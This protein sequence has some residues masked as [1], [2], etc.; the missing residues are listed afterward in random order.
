MLPLITNSTIGINHTG[1]Q[2]TSSTQPTKSEPGLSQE[3]SV[4]TEFRPKYAQIRGPQHP[5]A[6]RRSSSDSPN[7]ATSGTQS[8]EYNSADG[9]SPII[10]GEINESNQSGRKPGSVHSETGSNK[11]EE[12]GLRDGGGIRGSLRVL[13]EP[14]GSNNS[15]T[16][17]KGIP[18]KVKVDGKLIQFGPY[19]PARDAAIQYTRDAGIDYRPPTAYVKLNKERATRIAAAFDA[20]PHAPDDPATKA[21]YDALISETLAQYQAIKKTGL[22]VELI[23]EKNEAGELM[24]PY[25]NPRNVILDVINN[26]HLWISP[27]NEV[28]GSSETADVDVSGNL[29]LKPT[30]E[31]LNGH[32]LLANDIFRI[33]HDYFGH[34][35]EGFGFRAEGEENAWQQHVAMYSEKARPAMTTE[36]RG[37]N[38]WINFGPYAEFNK[39]ANV[40]DTQYAPQ[41]TGLLPDWVM[42]EGY[43]GGKPHDDAPA[44]KSIS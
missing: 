26:N 30:D 37:Q 36:L 11:A 39:T 4:E 3:C 10:K 12:G 16:P 19:Q 5:L 1:T 14:S 29:L 25:G 31:M 42:K 13:D 27:T 7:K 23:T 18:G 20:M 41:K 24:E 28:F 34:I 8:Q 6:S 9:R 44:A 35:K 40:T 17:L 38:S 43:E 15:P 33:T 32:T 2:T 21:S 22:K